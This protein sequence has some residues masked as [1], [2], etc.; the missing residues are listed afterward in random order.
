MST[1]TICTVVVAAPM[2][3]CG[4]PVVSTFT[5]RDGVVYGECADHCGDPHE[6]AGPSVVPPGA[7]PRTRSQAPFLLVRDG[8][9]VGYAYSRSDAVAKRAAR[10]GAK[11]IANVAH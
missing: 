5:S 4:Q 3:R 11:I 7:H 6:A 9:I 8:K 2:V 10:L 1:P